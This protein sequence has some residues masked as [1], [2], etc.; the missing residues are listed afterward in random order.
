M[1][2]EACQT[3]SGGRRDGRGAL[4]FYFDRLPKASNWNFL[5]LCEAKINIP[6]ICCFNS[7]M[8]SL[9]N[10]FVVSEKMFCLSNLGVS[11]HS[12]KSFKGTR[13]EI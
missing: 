2:E 9:F 3:L 5:V 10:Q 8:Q 6:R 12:I 7:E 11:L 13:R 4:E 1:E